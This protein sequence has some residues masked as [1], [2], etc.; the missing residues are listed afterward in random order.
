MKLAR[1]LSNDDNNN[2]SNINNNLEME[3][4]INKIL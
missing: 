1:E 2:K 4:N 3:K